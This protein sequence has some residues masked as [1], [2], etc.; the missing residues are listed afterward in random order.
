MLATGRDLELAQMVDSVEAV[1]LV[2]CH[3]IPGEVK[4]DEL[5][6]SPEV[7]H[8]PHSRYLV[9]PTVQLHQ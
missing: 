8:L 7:A 3:R 5:G 4:D 1:L 2:C 9:A 6:Q